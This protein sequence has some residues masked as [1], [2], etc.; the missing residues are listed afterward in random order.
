MKDIPSYY[1]SLPSHLLFRPISPP[2]NQFSPVRVHVTIGL[3]S[4][5]DRL[6]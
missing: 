2:D 6:A 3:A 1:Y 4:S 5:P